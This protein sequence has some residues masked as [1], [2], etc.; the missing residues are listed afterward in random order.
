LT[1]YPGFESALQAI[2]E[3][4]DEYLVKPANIKNLVGLIEEKL[5][6]KKPR[7]MRANKR[8][9]MILR[10]HVAEIVQRTLVAM[11][12][13]SDLSALP[14]T[15]GQR[16]A[17]LADA[18]G[19]LADFLDA[20]ETTRAS[21]DA[22]QRKHPLGLMVQNKR[23]IE[24]VISKVFYENLLS[25]DLSR[26]LPDM[27]RLNDAFL[28]QLATSIHAYLETEPT[29]VDLEYR[30][31]QGID[32]GP[33]P[34]SQEQLASI[35]DSAMDAIISLDAQQHVVLFNRAAEQLFG[36]SA[37]DALGSPLDRFLP[38]HLR[39]IHR[40][41]IGLFGATGVTS[42]SMRSPATLQAV[43]SNG[44]QFPIEATISQVGTGDRKRYTVILRDITYRKNTERALVQSEKLASI[45][46]LAT[47]I[48]HEINNPLEAIKNL[49]HLIQSNPSDLE[50]VRKYA[51]M[52]DS[53]VMRAA[54]IEGHVLG[55]SKG[56][57]QPRSCRVTELLEAVLALA[58]QKFVDKEAVC[59]KEYRQDAEVWGIASEIRQVFWNLL[60]NGLD[61][62]P[63]SGLI[64]VRV[65]GCH[66]PRHGRKGVRITVAD[67]GHGIRAEHVPHVFEPFYT[68]KP[69]GNGLGLW[70]AKQ[71]IDNYSGSIRVRSRASGPR[72]GSVFS[73]FLPDGF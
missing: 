9:S 50:M 60:A 68:T 63:E 46:R 15:D 56:G 26:L 24:Q 6:T 42:R 54:E 1:G 10:E 40:Q 49:L 57:G 73:I 34:A 16:V 45:G 13:D 27:A 72:T 3:Q 38:E 39:E 58:H 21:G 71:I 70:V 51:A 59:Q 19:Q 25:L 8:L 37:A 64:R 35:I 7:V 62:I 47:T 2:A 12:Q 20:T 69:N 28:W 31:E 14:L 41:H 67:N 29:P 17:G 48:A 23:I 52:A 4:V 5:T 43:R 65:A 44:E 30:S 53:E 18:V 55:W 33:P 61:A 32:A 22:A 36:C 66:H 11:K